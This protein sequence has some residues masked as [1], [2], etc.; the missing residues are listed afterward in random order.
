M[1]DRSTARRRWSPRC[2]ASPA[3]SLLPAHGQIN[4]G[5]TLSATGPGGV[6][7]HP[8]KNTFELLPTTI[9]GAEGQLDRARRRVRTRPRRSP[10]RRS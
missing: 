8:E 9:G 10:T 4:V 7:R 2:V 3:G 6:A 5:V 1:H